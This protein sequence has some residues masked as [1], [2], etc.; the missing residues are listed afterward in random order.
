MEWKDVKYWCLIIVLSYSP[1][2]LVHYAVRPMWFKS[3][4][5]HTSASL[6]ELFFTMLLLP[7][8]LTVVNYLIAKNYSKL[9]KSFFLNAIIIL[10]CIIISSELGLKNWTDSIGSANPDAETQGL[11]DF[12]RFV[13]I[14]VCLLGFII[15]YFLI[16][17]KTKSK[18]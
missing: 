14:S 17:R 8:Y 11:V 13:G 3:V 4:E 10:S 6:F 7:I 2:I 1:T 16:R 12:E 5:F 18:S 9:T 15:I